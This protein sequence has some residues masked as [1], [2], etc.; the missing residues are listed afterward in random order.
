MWE[1]DCHRIQRRRMMPLHMLRAQATVIVVENAMEKS[2]QAKE[3][4]LDVCV[5]QKMHMVFV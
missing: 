2:L 4:W 5:I 1:S 3:T